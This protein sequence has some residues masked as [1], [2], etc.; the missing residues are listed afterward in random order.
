LGQKIRE[1][2]KK[3][4]CGS[5]TEIKGTK[6]REKKVRQRERVRLED[7]YDLGL[8]IEKFRLNKRENVTEGPRRKNK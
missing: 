8:R 1:H 3:P 4:E 5:K 7:Q 6:D 2:G